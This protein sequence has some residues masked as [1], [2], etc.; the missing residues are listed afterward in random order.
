MSSCRSA[1]VFAGSQFLDVESLLD[2]LTAIVADPKQ[3]L[4]YFVKFALEVIF[5]ALRDEGSG[6]PDRFI[7]LTASLVQ[8]MRLLLVLTFRFFEH[9]IGHSDLVVELGSLNL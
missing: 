1:R 9:A 7:N 4:T 5:L 8:Q 6:V 3:F 2:N